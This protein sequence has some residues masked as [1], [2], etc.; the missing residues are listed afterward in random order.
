MPLSSIT[1]IPRIMRAKG[2][3]RGAALLERWFAGPS[4]AKPAYA[5]PDLTT[6]TMDWVLSFDRAKAVYDQMIN[7]QVWANQAAKPLVASRLRARGSVD[8]SFEYS[9][10]SPADMHGIHVNTRTVSGGYGTTFDGLVAA[11]GNFS[12]YVS[13]VS[14]ESTSKNGKLEI[15]ID[16]VGF[17]IVDSFDFEGDQYLGNWDENSNRVY[18][19][20]TKLGGTPVYN[21]TF[22]DWRRA[23]NKG[24]DFLVYTDVKMVDV[25]PPSVFVV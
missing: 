12:I 22:R 25:N 18:N 7:D 1:N 24:G 11:L 23:N 20:S 21:E 9:K 2:W 16:R 13:P 15:S 6:I 4:A 17:H 3:T 19:G 10:L 8:V 14:G 5:N